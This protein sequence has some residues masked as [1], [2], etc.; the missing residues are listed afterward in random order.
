MARVYNDRWGFFD[1]RA[2]ESAAQA[3]K[4]RPAPRDSGLP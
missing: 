1:L 3:P 4:S 2:I